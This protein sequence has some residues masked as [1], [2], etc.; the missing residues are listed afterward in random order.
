MRVRDAKMVLASRLL[1][2]YAIARYCA[3]PW[4]S[5]NATR[6]ANTKPVFRKPDGSE[7]LLFNI[8]HQDGLVVLLG[9]GNPPPGLAVGVDIVSPSER[10]DHDHETITREGWSTYVDI[11]AEVFAPEEASA[12]NALPFRRDTVKGRDEL[13]RYFYSLWCMREAY[14]KMTGEALLA[15]WL[16]QLDM[17]D[18]APPEVMAE[19]GRAQGAWMHGKKVAGV[20]VTLKDLSGRFMVCSAVREG[21]DGRTVEVGQYGELDVGEILAFAM[22]PDA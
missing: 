15:G 1:K 14:V 9:V 12:L 3:V 13:L 18:F 5:A 20:E 10:R 22:A 4:F 19:Q 6:D 21:K 7:P 8:T 2:R 17:R 11:H 16:R